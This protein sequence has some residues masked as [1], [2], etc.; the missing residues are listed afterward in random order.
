MTRRISEVKSS[1]PSKLTFLSS[2]Q[3]ILSFYFDGKLATTQSWVSTK[4]GEEKNGYNASIFLKLIFCYSTRYT[5]SFQ[6]KSFPAH[7]VL[8]GSSDSSVLES[9]E[10]MLWHSMRTIL[11]RDSFWK[12][13]NAFFLLWLE[14]PFQISYIHV[15]NVPSLNKVYQMLFTLQ[16]VSALLICLSY[17]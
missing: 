7:C 12:L 2:Q 6:N 16:V 3:Q 17:I 8:F 11:C 1:S 10:K 14:M 9:I 15:G 4:R 13:P 5:F